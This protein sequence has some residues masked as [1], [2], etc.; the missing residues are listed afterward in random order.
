MRLV[1]AGCALLEQEIRPLGH[2]VPD[3]GQ[4]VANGLRV[5]SR[6]VNGRYQLVAQGRHLLDGEQVGTRHVREH[7]MRLTNGLPPCLPVGPVRDN[8]GERI[9]HRRDLGRAEARA[10]LVPRTPVPEGQVEH[11]PEDQDHAPRHKHEGPT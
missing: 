3:A 4:L 9:D 6:S 2:H 5:S 8:V 11:A 7:L 10:S 1:A